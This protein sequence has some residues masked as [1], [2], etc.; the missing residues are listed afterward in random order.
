MNFQKSLEKMS[1][2]DIKLSF[3]III[4]KSVFEEG[5]TINE[6][7]LVSWGNE[8]NETYMK[9]IEK[10]M[11]Q[12]KIK[13]E[14]KSPSTISDITS[15]T[16]NCSNC[17]CRM[18][19]DTCLCIKCIRNNRKMPLPK[20][21]EEGE[22]LMT[23]R[24]F[25]IME[26]AIN[27]QKK[28]AR[29]LSED[30]F[31]RELDIKIGIVSI[32]LNDM[33]DKNRSFSKTRIKKFSENIEKFTEKQL[34]TTYYESL[35]HVIVCDEYSYD[36]AMELVATW[37]NLEAPFPFHVLKSRWL[38]DYSKKEAPPKENGYFFEPIL[39]ETPSQEETQLQIDNDIVENIQCTDE[40]YENK[41]IH[42]TSLF[43][44]LA[45]IYSLRLDGEVHDEFKARSYMN[46]CKRLKNI[47][48]ISNTDDIP[49]DIWPK[50]SKMWSHIREVVETNRLERLDILK[51]NPKIIA[52]RQFMKIHGI[53]PVRATKLYNL[54][55]KTIADLRTPAASKHL[56]PLEKICLSC[57]E[58]LQERIPRSE[59]EVFAQ[60]I[61]SYVTT[62]IH[63][64]IVLCVGS[65]RRGAETCGDID[66]LIFPPNG[67]STFGIIHKIHENFGIN[68]TN[69]LVYDLV[70]PYQNCNNYMGIAKLHTIGS[71]YRRIDIKVYDL[72]S[73]PYALLS[74]TGSDY[75][76]RSL[77]Y[78]AR[79]K[80]FSLSDKGLFVVKSRAIEYLRA[81]GRNSQADAV[82]LGACVPFCKNEFDIFKT[83]GL[84]SR[85]KEPSGRN[86]SIFE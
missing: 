62:T 73:K 43:E 60:Q 54:G 67:M 48:T 12:Q 80:G 28:R 4:P 39:G 2:S 83:L 8:I 68:G 84:E 51:N 82:K 25:S 45:D 65:F 31:L 57:Y 11:K 49:E 27:L 36:E 18:N 20:L 52:V 13:N 16:T 35:T 79:Q 24:E 71:K 32:P 72:L 21:D 6:E 22:W 59:V 50:T 5:T 70:T 66:I 44:E 47:P 69:L 64:A 34:S 56:S 9:P 85:Y 14:E 40:D 58:D 74:F 46:A 37:S 77:R 33:R 29:I 55:F 17:T 76:N 26:E 81:I 53:G 61:E 42:I 10:M 1:N 38:V 75:W 78:F 63:G 19:E 23:K 86:G 41:N 30:E 7:S 15:N 3:Q